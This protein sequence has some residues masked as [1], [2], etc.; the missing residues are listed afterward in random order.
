VWTVVLAAGAGTRLA[1]VTQGAPKQFWRLE[2]QPT[3]LEHTLNRLSAIA[4]PSRTVAV[5]AEQHHAHV[6]AAAEALHGRHVVYQSR[7]RGTA[8]GVVLGLLPVLEQDPEAIR[9]L[10]R[11]RR[12]EH[13][14]HHCPRADAVW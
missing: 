2:S 9:T 7:D 1:A 4:P 11:G 13:D 8:A 3:L 14:D 6:Q 10:Q 12:L 5:V